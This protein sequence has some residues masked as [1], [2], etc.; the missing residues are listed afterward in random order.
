M[1]LTKVKLRFE[2]DDKSR[3]R[4]GTFLRGGL[5]LLGWCQTKAHSK[6]KLLFNDTIFDQVN[7]YKVVLK[8]KVLNLSQF[9][10]LRSLLVTN[11]HKL[12][13]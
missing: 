7:V 3:T 8:T 2:K 1:K 4:L 12:C 5:G 11:P 13:R 6:P 9:S 10:S